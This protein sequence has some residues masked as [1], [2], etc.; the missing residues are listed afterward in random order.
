MINKGFKGGIMNCLAIVLNT[1]LAS[2]QAREL[3]TS[4]DTRYNP[5]DIFS[6]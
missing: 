2:L 4:V 5:L 6:D 3:F 1:H